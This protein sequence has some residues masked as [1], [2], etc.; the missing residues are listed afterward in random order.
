MLKSISKM[1]NKYFPIEEQA[2]EF[3]TFLKSMDEEGFAHL[4][5]NI[6]KEITDR[7][8]ITFTAYDGVN[9]SDLTDD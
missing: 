1:Y 5:E 6:P 7:E 8:P 3:A 9:V 4:L 2:E